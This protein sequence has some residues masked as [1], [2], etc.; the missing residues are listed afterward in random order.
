MTVPVVRGHS[1]KCLTCG[2]S[3]SGDAWI[4]APGSGDQWSRKHR[5]HEY[6]LHYN[7]DLC[8]SLEDRL[9][10]WRES[11]RPQPADY[12]SWLVDL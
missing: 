12:V 8:R 10:E 4:M 9:H 5:D 11:H 3:W 7:G 1:F 2:E 6:V